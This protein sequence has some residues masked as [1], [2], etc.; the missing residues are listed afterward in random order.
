MS[1]YQLVYDSAGNASVKT[2][3]VAVHPRITSTKGFNVSNYFA[4]RMDY[5]I[6]KPQYTKKAVNT[7]GA[8]STSVNNKILNI[9]SSDNKQST[10]SFNIESEGWEPDPYVRGLYIDPKTGAQVHRAP[11]TVSKPV[12]LGF[13]GTLMSWLAGFGVFGEVGQRVYQVKKTID[14]AIILNTTIQDLKTNYTDTGDNKT[15]VSKTAAMEDININQKP[16]FTPYKEPAK[17]TTPFHPSQGNGRE[18]QAQPSSRGD[19]GRAGGEQHET[20]GSF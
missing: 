6:E 10:K 11:K 16:V 5:G 2:V 4:P 9:V 12:E 19:A 8:Q 1:Q 14:K 15:N 13:F 17:T 18:S 7:I 3:A 20:I